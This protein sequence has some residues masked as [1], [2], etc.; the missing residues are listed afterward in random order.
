MRRTSDHIFDE[1][2]MSW[3]VNNS[4]VPFVRVKF[5]GCTRNG[6]TAFTF[7]LLTVHVEGKCKRS[8]TKAFSLLLQLLELALRE[9]TKLKN[10]PTCGR[11]FT[12]VDMATDDD[13]KM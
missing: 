12:A 10:E 2:A 7:L 1:V 4:V 13:G 9:T 3:G 8:L 11:T 5:L 6:D